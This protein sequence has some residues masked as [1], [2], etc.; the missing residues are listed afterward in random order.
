MV[1]SSNIGRLDYLY[2]L[3]TSKTY[4]RKQSLEDIVDVSLIEHFLIRKSLY[5]LSMHLDLCWNPK[6]RWIEELVQD[7]IQ[8]TILL[9]QPPEQRLNV[10]HTYLK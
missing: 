5:L 8:D 9:N 3:L 1:R 7:K 10:R 4:H 2:E 6:D